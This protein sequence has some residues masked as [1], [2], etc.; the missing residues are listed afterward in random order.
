M[1]RLGNRSQDYSF[2]GNFV[3]GTLDLSCRGP[4]VHL[5]AEQY[6]V[7]NSDGAQ[8]LYTVRSARTIFWL[9]GQGQAP[10]LPF[11]SFSLPRDPPI[12]PSSPLSLPSLSPPWLPWIISQIRFNKLSAVFFK[13]CYTKLATQCVS[14]EDWDTSP[15]AVNLQNPVIAVQS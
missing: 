10:P 9:V 11:S 8:P 15:S 2:P 6:L 12:S 13:I 14:R 5:S 7:W 4:F 3:P 1:I